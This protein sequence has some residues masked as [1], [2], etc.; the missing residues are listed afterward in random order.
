ME[1]KHTLEVSKKLVILDQ[2]EEFYKEYTNG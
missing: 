2:R 1:K